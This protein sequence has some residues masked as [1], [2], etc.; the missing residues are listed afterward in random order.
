M[1][2]MGE[3]RFIKKSEIAGRA[4]R[5][6]I[7]A[8]TEPRNKL[9]IRGPMCKYCPGCEA[10]DPNL[11]GIVEEGRYCSQTMFGVKYPKGFDW[12]RF[13]DILQDRFWIVA[14]HFGFGDD[15]KDGYFYSANGMRIGFIREDQQL[16]RNI[17]SVLAA[18]GMALQECGVSV[19]W[20]R[21]VEE[22]AKVLEEYRDIGFTMYM[23]DDGPASRRST[24]NKPVAKPASTRKR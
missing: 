1:E 23:Q 24:P 20:K 9:V 3:E 15:R 4:I 7:R 18:T 6:G 12:K 13:M 10:V 14:P 2:M 22:A 8:M 11:A 5:I 19:D 21:G 16:P 17:I